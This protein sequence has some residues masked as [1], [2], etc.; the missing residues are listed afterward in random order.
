MPDINLKDEEDFTED[1]S[2]QEKPGRAKFY[3]DEGSGNSNKKLVFLIIIILLI[4]GVVLLNQF[5]VLNLWGTGDSKVTVVLPPLEE[6]TL[7]PVPEPRALELTPAPEAD[8]PRPGEPTTE[9]TA[10]LPAERIPESAAPRPGER[11]PETAAIR[12]GEPVTRPAAEREITFPIDGPPPGTGRFTLQIS[13]WQSRTN[14]EREAKQLRDTG[15]EAF[16][17]Q[18]TVNGTT[19]Y[20]VRLGRYQTYEAAENA[21]HAL[22]S[23]LEAG[24][25]VDFIDN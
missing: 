25:W 10:P 17:S 23:L 9:T 13:S 19:W 18:S 14:A 2:I 5:G 12:P 16:I 21:A 22:E 20:R 8:L 11:T 7:E 3:G 15:E 24:W 1:N 4:I 6:E